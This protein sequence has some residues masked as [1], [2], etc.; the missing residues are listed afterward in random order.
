MSP[1]TP[2]PHEPHETLYIQPFAYALLWGALVYTAAEV[3]RVV[4]LIPLNPDQN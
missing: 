2:P 3:E 4:R 1:D